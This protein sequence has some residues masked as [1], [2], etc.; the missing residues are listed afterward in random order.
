MPEISEER[1]QAIFE[2]LDKINESLN[3]FKVDVSKKIATHE[4][5]IKGVKARFVILTTI[6]L[7]FFSAAVGL[8][9]KVL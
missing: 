1:I 9:L 4:E 7:A 8:A 3:N 6:F 5:A 2:K